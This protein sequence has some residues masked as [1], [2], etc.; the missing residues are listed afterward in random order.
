MAY[1]NC[2]WAQ[3]S[4]V[5]L[6]RDCPPQA[7]VGDALSFVPDIDGSAY[8]KA[9]GSAYGIFLIGPST[10]YFDAALV[11]ASYAGTI[12]GISLI[13]G[14]DGSGPDTLGALEDALPGG[15]VFSPVSMAFPIA[16]GTAYDGTIGG[17]A[18]AGQSNKYY[19]GRVVVGSET[20]YGLFAVGGGI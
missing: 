7:P 10:E 11:A 3:D 12:T 2:F 1:E 9:D 8:Q 20:F 4:V 18:A 14:Y 16:D 5:G 6:T 17:Y 19:Y 13:K 15:V